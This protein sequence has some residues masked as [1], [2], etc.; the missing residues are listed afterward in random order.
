M[1]FIDDRDHNNS[2]D[3]EL[4]NMKVKSHPPTQQ[5]PIDLDLEL[6]LGSVPKKVS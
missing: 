3:K 5:L 4:T 2:G 6:V 1:K